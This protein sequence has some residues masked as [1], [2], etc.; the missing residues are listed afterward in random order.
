MR[1]VVIDEA[2]ALLHGVNRKDVDSL[3]AAVPKSAQRVLASATGGRSEAQDALESLAGR[4]LTLCGLPSSTQSIALPDTVAHGHLV[5]EQRRMLD[6]LRSLLH[7]DPMPEVVL[8]FVNEP[9]RVQVVC[10]KLLE[11]GIIAAPLTGETSKEDRTDVMRRLSSGRL[12]LVVTTELAARGL[13]APCL[14]HV[15]NLDLPTDATHYAHRAGR[16]GRAGRPGIVVSFVSPKTAFVVDKFASVLQVPIPE[17]VL[18]SS[19][20]LMPD[21]RMNAEEAAA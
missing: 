16:V 4:S 9:R 1:A 21:P 19:K 12:G 7:T 10:D 14:T 20:L 3:L 13:D 15:V 8:V 5:V 11:Q 18:Y 17:M 6:A 2:D